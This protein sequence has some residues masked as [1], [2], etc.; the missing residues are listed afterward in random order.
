MT[1]ATSTTEPVPPTLTEPAAAPPE[2]G[3]GAGRDGRAEDLRQ[4]A[5]I[6][7]DTETAFNTHDADLLV[8]HFA[9]DV[10]TVGVTGAVLRGR[11]EALE[12]SRR[13]FAG[14]LADQYARYEVDE[15]RFLGDDVALVRKLATATDAEGVDLD[16]DHTMVAHYVLARRD[17]RWWVALRQ[18][19]LIAR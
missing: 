15:V 7:T 16:L 1:S 13:L 10:T 3:D 14:P 19:T 12:T 9:A 4:I 2:G 8:A 6:V 17:G 11:D 5:R 18:N